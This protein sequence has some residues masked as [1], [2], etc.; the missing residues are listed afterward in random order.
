MNGAVSNNGALTQIKNVPGSATTEFLHLT[1]A[2]AT[3]DKYHGVDMTPGV[4]AMGVTTVTVKGNQSA[5]TTN[6]FD[7]ILQ[8][9]YRIDPNTQTSAT[10][11]F[12]FTEA[13]RNNQAANQLKLW[14]WGPWTQVGTL[15]NYSYSESGTPCVSGGGQAC[16]F[17]STGVS[18]YSPFALGSGATPTAVHLTQ[19]DGRSP[20][21]ALP[22]LPLGALI[23]I[24]LSLSAIVLKRRHS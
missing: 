16:W 9:C 18:S 7:P 5:C 4:T 19:F 23:A 20:L 17:Q 8:R 2:A 11:R 14:H 24:G 21:T 12:W 22:W 10:V 1:N 13:E 3:V 6:A 15:V